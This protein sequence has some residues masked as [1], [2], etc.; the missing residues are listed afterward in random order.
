MVWAAA[1]ERRNAL[2]AHRDISDLEEKDN[3]DILIVTKA[4]GVISN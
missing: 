2:K 1:A 4:S 3:R